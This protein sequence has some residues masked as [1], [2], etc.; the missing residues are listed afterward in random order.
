MFYTR[1]LYRIWEHKN[2]L[3]PTKSCLQYGPFTSLYERKIFS[4]SLYTWVNWGTDCLMV[5]CFRGE[6][7]IA[8]VNID[9]YRIWR[10]LSTSKKKF[11]GKV[12]HDLSHSHHAM[13][14]PLQDATWIFPHHLQASTLLQCNLDI[15]PKCFSLFSFL[16]APPSPSGGPSPL[17]WRVSLEQLGQRDLQ[18][19]PNPPQPRGKRRRRAVMGRGEEQKT[20]ALLPSPNYS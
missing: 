15:I 5:W 11:V 4:F 8:T 3:S 10:K 16:S 9:F 20:K 14:R 18:N 2:H 17:V 1:I 19:S 13:P 12:L 6:H 7:H